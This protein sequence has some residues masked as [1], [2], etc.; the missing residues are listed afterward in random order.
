MSKETDNI[1]FV[2]TFQRAAG[3]K[4]D[5][6]AGKET[7]NK[8]TT[9]TGI[10]FDE[11]PDSDF[12]KRALDLILEFEGFDQPSRWPGG[13]SGITIG[14]GYDLGYV[15]RDE[16]SRDWSPHLTTDAILRLSEVVGKKGESAHLRAGAFTDIH[17]P[18]EAA[19]Q[20]FMER[21]L[22][23]FIDQTA[24]AFEGSTSLPKDAF[25]A[26]VSLV[27]NRGTAM[28]GSTRIEMRQIRDSIKAGNPSQVPN[29]IRQMKRLWVGRN[30]DGLLRRR[31]AEADLFDSAL[32]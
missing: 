5:G 29:A 3:L 19:I 11:I 20:V 9:W 30:L 24:K 2:K 10:T 16:F 4:E 26:L 32:V 27:F 18:K 12:S 14:V 1:L 8:L 13:A 6:W 17:I 22:P 28:Q 15:T 31:D 21:T 7:R 25:G 23:K